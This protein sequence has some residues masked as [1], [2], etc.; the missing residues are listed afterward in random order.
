MLAVQAPAPTSL[1]TIDLLYRLYM[2]SAEVDVKIEPHQMSNRPFSAPFQSIPC[3]RASGTT[4][5]I[6]NLDFD[7]HTI[8]VTH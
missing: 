3:I 1:C 7:K 4:A 2:S 5:L 6:I 8:L